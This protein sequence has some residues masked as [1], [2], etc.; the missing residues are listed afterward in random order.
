VADVTGGHAATFV[1]AMGAVAIG[2]L[3]LVFLRSPKQGAPAGS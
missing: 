2:A 3:M 1:V